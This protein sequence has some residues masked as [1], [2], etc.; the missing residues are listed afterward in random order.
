MATEDT[1]FCNNTTLSKTTHLLRLG[2]GLLLLGIGLLLG[3]G[4]LLGLLLGK[5]LYGM[6]TRHGVMFWPYQSEI[7][8]LAASHSPR[9]AT[10]ACVSSLLR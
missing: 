6:G 9:R 10:W 8:V 2:I 3:V 4:L 7:A 5:I 1:P